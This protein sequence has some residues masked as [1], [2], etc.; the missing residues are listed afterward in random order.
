M[1]KIIYDLEITGFGDNEIVS[2][3]CHVLNH[4]NAHIGSFYSLIK[5]DGAMGSRAKKMTG[6][7]NS[8]LKS[9]S[10]FKDV[11]DMLEKWL[12]I[13]LNID[14]KDCE[15]IAYGEDSKVLRRMCKLHNIDFNQYIGK[16]K[17][18]DIQKI[19]SKKVKHNDKPIAER[20]SLHNMKSI[21]NIPGSVSHNA[22]DDAH[23]AMDIYLSWK[24]G[25]EMDEKIIEE[26]YEKRKGN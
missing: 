19:L 26:I 15:W 2:I 7:K 3:G 18:S 17:V 13:C 21:Y 10:E 5:P 20:I 6:L 11:M 22:L 14:V 9:A 8:D 25:K 23:D 16:N 4:R 1:N 24:N 12:K